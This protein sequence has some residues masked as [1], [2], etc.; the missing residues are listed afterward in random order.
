M[1]SRSSTPARKSAAFRV[2]PGGFEVS[3]RTYCCRSCA[4]SSEDCATDA[5]QAKEA[6]EAKDAR[7]ISTTEDAEDTEITLRLCDRRRARQL[8][9]SM[10]VLFSAISTL[11][12]SR[13]TKIWIVES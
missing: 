8:G 2:S 12:R 1:P 7:E 5:K 6:K 3:M 4:A 10:C 11:P 9:S 13:V